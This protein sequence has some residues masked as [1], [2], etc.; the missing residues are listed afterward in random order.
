MDNLTL[1]LACTDSS[2]YINFLYIQ[3]PLFSVTPD[4]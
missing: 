4:Q 2:L 1:A 3:S